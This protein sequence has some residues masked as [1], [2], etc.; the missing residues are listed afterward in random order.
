MVLNGL[1][2]LN[3]WKFILHIYDSSEFS[4]LPTRNGLPTTPSR[5]LELAQ[6]FLTTPLDIAVIPKI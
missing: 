2:G 6:T 3:G 4:K 1:N 5:P